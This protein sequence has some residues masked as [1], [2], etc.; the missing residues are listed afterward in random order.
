MLLCNTSVT[1]CDGVLT[2]SS[3]VWVTLL[4][5]FVNLSLYC[6]HAVDI[7]SLILLNDLNQSII[8]T[9]TS[10]VPVIMFTN[11][12]EIISFNFSNR[13]EIPVFNVSR[14]FSINPFSGMILSSSSFS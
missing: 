9:T 14:D 13:D 8:F 10:L 4:Q 2:T 7:Y 1:I 5:T 12:F 3:I 11:W 6:N